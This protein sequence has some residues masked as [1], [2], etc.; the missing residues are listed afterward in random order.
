MSQELKTKR[1]KNPEINNS[2]CPHYCSLNLFIMLFFCLFR[3][4]DAH[5]AVI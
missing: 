3:I 2:G 5:D 4:A 1:D